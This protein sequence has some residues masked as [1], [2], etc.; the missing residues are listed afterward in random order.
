MAYTTSNLQPKPLAPARPAR[1]K[2][3]L[4]VELARNEHDIVASQKLRYEIFARESGALLHNTIP[5][6]DHDRF[7]PFCQHMLVRDESTND[8]VASTR[9]L[10]DEAARKAGGF[11]SGSEFD[12]SAVLA[13]PGRKMEI[14]RTCV[15]ADY[16]NGSAITMLWNGLAEYLLGHRFD[17]LM[18]CASICLRDGGMQAQTIMRD[19]R[20]NALT[21]PDCRVTPLLPFPA[22]PVAADL[23]PQ[24]PP[25]LKAYLRVGAKIGGE[26]FW[27]KDFNVADVF[28]LLPVAALEARYARHFIG[29]RQEQ[30]A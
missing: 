21:E 28:V 20:A 22:H 7:D 10:T 29:R 3:R 17:Y 24:M 30:P 8:I 4:V 14:G 27:D 19:I 18:G 25:L 12:L 9:I 1:E 6:V 5:G 15:H 2:P 11:Y 16:R 26:P 13:L 23:K